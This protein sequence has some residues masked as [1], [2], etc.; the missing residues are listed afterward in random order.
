MTDWPPPRSESDKPWE[1]WIE[2]IGQQW[3]DDWLQGKTPPE[4][5]TWW[6]TVQA[7][8]GCTLSDLCGDTELCRA[9]IQICA[10]SDTACA[11]VGVP[12]DPSRPRSKLWWKAA[13]RLINS[14]NRPSG[15]TLCNHE[16]LPWCVRVLPKFHTPQTGITIRSLSHHLALCPTEEVVPSWLTPK[17]ESKRLPSTDPRLRNVLLVPWPLEIRRK[18][19]RPASPPQGNLGNMDLRFGFFWFDKPREPDEVIREKLGALYKAAIEEAGFVDLIV[20]PELALDPEELKVAQEWAQGHRVLL[21]SGVG[22][23]PAQPAPG[24]NYVAFALPGLSDPIRQPKHHR[25]QLDRSQIETYGLGGYLNTEKLWWEQVVT[26]DRS[27]KFISL[28]PWLNVCVLVCEDLAQQEPVARMVRAVGP[29]LVIAVLMDGPQLNSRWPARYATVLAD[30]PG[31]S[32]LTITSLGMC[33]RSRPP[34]YGVSRVIALWKDNRS[35]AAREIEIS[36]GADAVML[37]LLVEKTEEFTADG[38]SDRCQAGRPVLTGAYDI[39]LS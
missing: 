29:N 26:S 15:A 6:D 23:P 2:G 24:H 21:I 34:G 31:S 22:E 17:L 8:L 13:T 7:K 20:L 10:A 12:Y 33:K 5:Q 18:Q 27:L 37:N 1:V 4:V 28:L 38:R 25:W 19:L 9:L 11:G 32:V 39:R 36:D 16:I 3:R 30:D 14:T 35:G